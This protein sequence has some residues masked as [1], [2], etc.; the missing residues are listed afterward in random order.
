MSPI[1]STE[2]ALILT[3]DI[4]GKLPVP[5]KVEEVA[6]SNIYNV[7][8]KRRMSRV[9]IPESLKLSLFLKLNAE[10]KHDADDWVD[11]IETA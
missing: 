4:L 10:I 9:Q 3:K 11:R 5:F 1:G 8:F 2:N 7:C 6:V